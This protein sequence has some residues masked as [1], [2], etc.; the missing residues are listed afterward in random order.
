MNERVL[1]IIVTVLGL[2]F[3]AYLTAFQMRDRTTVDQ[4]Q[5]V[6]ETSFQIH[7][8]FLAT[9][10]VRRPFARPLYGFLLG[11]GLLAVAFLLLP[12][13]Y[14]HPFPDNGGIRWRIID[15]TISPLIIVGLFSFHSALL[16]ITSKRRSLTQAA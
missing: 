6:L 10:I 1:R 2:G 15:A 4:L 14:A 7:A 9:Y 3:I 12:Y 5:A 11:A 13:S 16:R 8:L